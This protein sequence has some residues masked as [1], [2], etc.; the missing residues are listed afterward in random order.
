MTIKQLEYLEILLKILIFKF[1]RCILE[2][3]LKV[4]LMQKS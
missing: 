4:N 1:D 2:V 3:Q